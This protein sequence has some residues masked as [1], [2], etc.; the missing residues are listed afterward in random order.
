MYI[1]SVNQNMKAKVV[2]CGKA[3]HFTILDAGMIEYGTS[4]EFALVKQRAGYMT[5][6]EID[7]F[8]TLL[9]TLAPPSV[10]WMKSRYISQLGC[11]IGQISA[12]KKKKRGRE[13]EG[14]K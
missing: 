13:R 12:T 6:R 11:C 4:M 9:I 5:L 7:S 8:P 1:A 14:E 10:F 3:E 2:F